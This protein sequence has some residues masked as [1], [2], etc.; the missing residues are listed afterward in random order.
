[1]SFWSLAPFK[2]YKN[3]FWNIQKNVHNRAKKK[4]KMAQ[5]LRNSFNA[6][7]ELD[8]VSSGNNPKNS[9]FTDRLR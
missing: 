6:D 4:G 9:E 8:D 1:M 2:L 3:V 5:Q 7:Y